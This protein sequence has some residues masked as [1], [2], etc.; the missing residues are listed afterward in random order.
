MLPLVGGFLLDK[1]GTRKALILFTVLICIGQG[2]FMLGGYQNSYTLML[3]G[4]FVFGIGCEN[5]YVGQSAMIAEWFINFELPLAISLISS[6]PLFGSFLN[7]AVTPR[8]YESAQNDDEDNQQ[9]LGDAFRI[10]FYQ[11]LGS[12]VLV[13]ALTVLDYRTLKH[14]TKKLE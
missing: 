4:R 2:L 6:I 7:G 14:D 12:L 13:I 11:C 10:G 1:I 3:T 9:S 5:M 8:V